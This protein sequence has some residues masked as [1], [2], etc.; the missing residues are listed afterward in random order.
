[1]RKK[2]L[3][4]PAART[5]SVV[6]WLFLIMIPTAQSELRACYPQ[7]SGL[8]WNP[9]YTY[10]IGAQDCVAGYLCENGACYNAACGGIGWWQR[11]V[12]WYN[13]GLISLCYST[14]GCA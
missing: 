11:C 5:A 13:C 8:Q 1:M 3:T 7:A 9:N 4:H 2:W 14:G 6:L 12:E 10:C